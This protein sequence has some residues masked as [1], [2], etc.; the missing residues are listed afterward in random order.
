MSP[1]YIR[2][3]SHTQHVALRSFIAWLQVS[4]V[5]VDRCESLRLQRNA[6]TKGN[7]TP[8]CLIGRSSEDTGTMHVRISLQFCFVRFGEKAPPVGQGLLIDEVSRSHTHDDVP[9]SVG[10]TWT[11][12][13]LVE[14]TST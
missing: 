6:A 13:Q 11:S 1:V 9:Q 5:H 2:D 7:R 3:H 10:L 14:E 12:D 8:T 4:A